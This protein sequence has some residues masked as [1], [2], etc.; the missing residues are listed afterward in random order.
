MAPFFCAEMQWARMAYS[1]SAE[2]GNAHGDEF[3][4]PAGQRAVAE[5][6]LEEAGDAFGDVGRVGKSFKHVGDD[7]SLSEEGVVDG[8]GLGGYGSRSSS[9]MR[10]V[11]L[12]I[13]SI[14]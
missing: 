13:G 12:D 1:H 10:G 6:R 4:V 14:F 9:L 11:G 5:E 3:F 8:G 2:D 7:A